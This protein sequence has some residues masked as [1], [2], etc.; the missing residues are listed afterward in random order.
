MGQV[1][2]A[3]VSSKYLERK[4][5]KYMRV[6]SC[7]MQ[8]YRVNMEDTHTLQLSLGDKHPE[9]SF[10]AVFDGH[11]GDK[12]SIFMAEKLW[13]A[14]AKLEDPTNKETLI[15]CIQN[16]DQEFLRSKEED[17]ENGSTAVFA[18][19]DPIKKNGEVTAW[20]ITIGNLG[21]SRAIVIKKDGKLESLTK[22]HKPE[23]KEEELRIQKAGGFVRQNRV[24]GQLAMSRA[25]GD[26]KYKDQPNLK[27]DKQKVIAVP[28]IE[29]ITVEK[30]DRLVLFCDGIVEQ[31]QN[32]DV[33]QFIHKEMKES[34]NVQDPASVLVRLID[35]SLL[36]GSKDNMSAL[37]VIFDDGTDYNLKAEF[38][39][40]P[41][42]PHKS[43]EAFRNAYLAD[44]KRC[45]YQGDELMEM[46]KK[47]EE[48]MKSQPALPAPDPQGPN[49]MLK[50]LIQSLASNLGGL[51][52]ENREEKAMALMAFLQ[53][54][55]I[56]DNNDHDGDTHMKTD[57][58]KDGPKITEDTSDVDMSTS[59]TTSTT[60]NNNTSNNNSSHT[61]SSTSPISPTT[62]GKKKKKKKKKKSTTSNT[63]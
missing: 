50:S 1:L 18:I 6:G 31:M 45:G 21:D 47:A 54:G 59:S 24:D 53:G 33:S 52:G 40:G 15:K 49:M 2:S 44:A 41:F 55:Q 32:E 38:L 12:A 60:T 58:E 62:P 25:I 26:S 5:N 17:R 22:D 16:L 36:K 35:L 7:E 10:F 8:G 20:H 11:G 29:Q 19:V 14:V 46:A 23:T 3:P 57:K 39:A 27:A 13:Q 4:G 34:K 63:V 42:H 61:A 9:K 56:F 37:M 48:A 28:D 30:G 43:D 51:P